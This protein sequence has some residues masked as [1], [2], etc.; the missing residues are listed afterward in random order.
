MCES[1]SVVLEIRAVF[2]FFINGNVID[3]QLN[4]GGVNLNN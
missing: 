2:D 3:K 1:V 4:A